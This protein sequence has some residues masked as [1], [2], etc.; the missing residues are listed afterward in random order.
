MSGWRCC[1]VGGKTLQ[2][3]REQYYATNNLSA[4]SN[5]VP[6]GVRKVDRWCHNKQCRL[7][8][9]KVHVGPGTKVCLQA[10]GGC[11]IALKGS[12]PPGGK[13]M[14]AITNS[15]AMPPNMQHMPSAAGVRVA[16]A[17]ATTSPQP[18][19]SWSAPMD[20]GSAPRSQA[21]TGPVREPNRSRT[22]G[23]MGKGRGRGGGKS[24][25]TCERG[26]QDTHAEGSA[27]EMRQGLC[28]D[29]DAER[30][31]N[32]WDDGWTTG[33]RYLGQRVR[34][35]LPE[36]KH[37][38]PIDGTVEKWLPADKS[39]FTSEATNE[40]AAL[41][42]I[43]FDD[44]TVGEE[45]MEEHEIK[46][47]ILRFRWSHGAGLVGQ[48]V[49]RLFEGYGEL[50]GEVR[51]YEEDEDAK[52]VRE[53]VTNVTED[54]Y[55]DAQLVLETY[56]RK[57]Q[58]TLHGGTIPA[59]GKF[60]VKYANGVFEEELSW[61]ELTASALSGANSHA[62]CA[63]GPLLKQTFH[64]PAQSHASASSSAAPEGYKPS[65]G[66]GKKR[67]HSGGREGTPGRVGGAGA[68]GGAGEAVALR[69]AERLSIRSL[70]PDV[71]ERPRKLL[72]DAAL[73]SSG[74]GLGCVGNAQAGEGE[75]LDVKV[76]V[77]RERETE[78]MT[79]T[80]QRVSGDAV[81]AHEGEDDGC[82]KM[83]DG[84]SMNVKDIN[85]MLINQ[86]PLPV[87]L[88]V[89]VRYI[90]CVCICVCLCVCVC[91]YVCMCVC[92]YVCI[93]IYIDDVDKVLLVCVD[94]WVCHTATARGG[95]SWK[96]LSRARA[97][98]R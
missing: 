53:S 19:T 18:V 89:K 82:I 72:C 36:G 43:V 21:A 87:V 22:L 23:S 34:R 24:A 78:R 63:E 95:R 7:F 32:S 27:G 38:R 56:A 14:V 74:V 2:E 88:D 5:I 84:Q 79:R 13:D 71:F 28:A 31:I 57:L 15:S 4:S 17:A 45:D 62:H 48:R 91:M 55:R 12:A 30:D 96:L 11:G 80:K 26:G 16:A 94:K 73:C 52:K 29:T 44:R 98:S 49:L 81:E 54:E 65:T 97:Q 76:G 39:D 68:G 59:L 67:G 58:V 9:Q 92:M 40:P 60:K 85:L 20:T 77:K 75:G 37:D 42:H 50:V 35:I 25:K 51:E 93:H 33:S 46:E 90:V 10:R 1:Y 8:A 64:H 6:G 70:L 47:A 69:P 86:P 41:W 61:Q 66:S 83:Q 3:I